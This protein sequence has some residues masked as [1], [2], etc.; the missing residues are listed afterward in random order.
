MC[1]VYLSDKILFIYVNYL[2]FEVI[3]PLVVKSTNRELGRGA[4]LSSI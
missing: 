2:D 1:H 4:E 3:T